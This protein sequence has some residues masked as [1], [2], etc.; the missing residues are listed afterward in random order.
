M[1]KVKIVADEFGNV[2]RVSQNNPDYG[3]VRV[4]QDAIEVSNG[5]VRRKVR[6]SI[7]P[8]LVADLKMI[9]WKAN[10]ELEGKITVKEGLD[11]IMESNP[12]FGI[13]R[14]GENGPV[15][16]FEDQA[17]YRRTYYTLDLTDVDN[18]IQHTNVAQIKEANAE[19]N[20]NSTENVNIIKSAMKE[21][22]TLDL[23]ETEEMDIP[24]TAE[25]KEEVTFDF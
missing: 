23:D 17:I 12:E 5:W 13:K 21:I 4:E 2:I 16:L 11:P 19:R 10:Q 3:F 7:V 14:A 8:G 24:V 1:N 25:S 15:C 18:F 20:S 22:E 9:G 6:S